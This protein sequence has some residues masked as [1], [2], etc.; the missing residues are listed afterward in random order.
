VVEYWIAAVPIAW[1]VVPNGRDAMEGESFERSAT[2]LQTVVYR[3]Y[4]PNWERPLPGQG[5][6]G[7]PLIRARVG[8]TLLVHF[9]NLDDVFNRPH[10]MHFHG[11]HYKPG[12]DGA[13]IPGFSGPG[14]NVKPGQTFTYR[15][16]VAP[17]SKGVWPYHDHSPSMHESLMGGLYGAL[18]IRGRGEPLPDRE[19][20]VFFGS[21][22]GFN[23]INGRAFVGNTPVFR[24][25]PGEDV[26]WDVLNI[27]DDFHTFHVHGHRWRTPAGDVIDTRTVGPAESFSVR[28]QE[29][30]AGAWL[31]HCHV[32]SHMMNGM[33]GIYVVKPR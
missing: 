23:T 1:N 20:V 12:S 13:F 10:S 30:A 22:L 14:G 4:T 24:G 16:V 19:F 8:D 3:A 28:W 9:Q 26:Q 27:G 5:G 11:V 7:R 32:E 15:L 25:R 17:D 6:I 31:Y 33:I 18:S 2:T 29:D 21:Q